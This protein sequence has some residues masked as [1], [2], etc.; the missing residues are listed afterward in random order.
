M[1]TRTTYMVAWAREISVFVTYLEIM[2]KQCPVLTRAASHML[3]VDVYS[4]S[5]DI[6][7]KHLRS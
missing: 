4:K 2:S 1:L 3:K 5:R 7:S 6:L